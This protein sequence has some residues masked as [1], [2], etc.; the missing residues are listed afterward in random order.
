MM[1]G[2]LVKYHGSIYRITS[3]YDDG[4]IDICPVWSIEPIENVSR[5]EVKN[6]V[7]EKD[8]YVS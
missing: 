4:T 6:G 7:K 5:L 1:I 3:T 8:L 2:D